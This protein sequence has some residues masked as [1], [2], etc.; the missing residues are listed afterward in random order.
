MYIYIY[1]YIF[2]YNI[3]WGRRISRGPSLWTPISS[4][5]N[6]DSRRFPDGDVGTDRSKILSSRLGSRA[7]LSGRFRH[8]RSSSVARRG[9][10]RSKG[11]FT[12][13][14]EILWY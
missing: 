1:I 2:I 10:P 12:I 7:L 8:L 6:R 4:L 3:F 5:W 14:S 9:T 13:G 11:Y